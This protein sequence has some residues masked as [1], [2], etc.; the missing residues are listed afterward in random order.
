MTIR[1]RLILLTSAGLL[2]LIATNLYLTRAITDNSAGMVKAAGLLAGIEKA[3]NARIAFGELRY[4]MTD[5]AVSQL[6]LSERKA[7]AARARMQ[8]YLRKRYGAGRGPSHI[9]CGVSVEDRKATAR[10]A[11]LRECAAGVRF[12]SIEPLIG[13][14]GTIDPAGRD[15]GR[16]T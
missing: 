15:G 13:A 7:A 11:H 2:V 16:R 8:D 12:L 5:L 14:V 6:T 1:T 4:C 3:D 10:I 9:W